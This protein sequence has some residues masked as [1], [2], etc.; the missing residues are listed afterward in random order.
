MQNP[1]VYG[2]NKQ[3]S[4]YIILLWHFAKLPS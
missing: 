3:V 2:A 1:S 4:H